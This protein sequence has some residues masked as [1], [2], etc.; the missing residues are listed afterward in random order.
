MYGLKGKHEPG[1]YWYC[2]VL[3]IK[4]GSDSLV[5]TVTVETISHSKSG[6]VQRKP[7]DVDVR[8]LVILQS[9]GGEQAEAQTTNQ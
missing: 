4:E 9:L 1:A 7:F 5:R 2:R 6:K 3:S 8:H